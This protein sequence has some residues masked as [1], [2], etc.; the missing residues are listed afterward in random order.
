MT[1]FDE[2]KNELTLPEGLGWD[3]VIEMDKQTHPEKT[4]LELPKGLEWNDVPDL[5]SDYEYIKTLPESKTGI[6]GD[7]GSG[8]AKGVLGFNEMAWRGLRSLDPPGG[9][10]VVRDLATRGLKDVKSTEEDYPRIFKPS[11][12]T[13]QSGFRKGVYETFASGVPSIGTALAVSATGGGSLAVGLIT[14]AFFGTSQYDQVLEEGK[15]AGRSYK[16]TVPYAIASGLVEGA[17]EGLANAIGARIFGLDGPAAATFK[18]T[19]KNALFKGISGFLKSNLKQLPVELGTEYG[20]QVGEE[21][22]QNLQGLSDKNPF[23]SGLD[24]IPATIG[25]T[26]LFGAG[27]SMLTRGRRK[28]TLSM[29]SDGTA[30]PVKRS[31]AAAVIGEALAQKDQKLASEWMQIS[32]R[33]I[34]DAKPMPIDAKIGTLVADAGTTMDPDAERVKVLDGVRNDL[35]AGTIT[36]AHI[37]LIKDQFPELK[38]D[39][40]KILSDYAVASVA[41][42]LEKD[43]TV[44]KVPKSKEIEKEIE[45]AKRIGTGIVETGNKE[46][47]KREEEKRLYLRDIEEN[48]LAATKGTPEEPLKSTGVVEKPGPIPTKPSGEVVAPGGVK[49][50]GKGEASAVDGTLQSVI[51]S[52]MD[53]H[54]MARHIFTARVRQQAKLNDEQTQDLFLRSEYVDDAMPRIDAAYKSGATKEDILTEADKFAVTVKQWMGKDVGKLGPA[55]TKAKPTIEMLPVLE[56]TEAALAFGE[57]ATVEQ[58]KLLNQRREAF[59]QRSKELKDAGDYNGAMVEATNAQFD[60]EA[61]EV[62]AAK[63]A[64]T[65][66]A[67]ETTPPLPT[68]PQM[69]AEARRWKGAAFKADQLYPVE[70]TKGRLKHSNMTTKG[71]LDAY[72]MMKFGVDET[73]ARNVSNELTRQNLKPA[74]EAKIEDFAGE[75]WAKVK[76]QPEVEKPAVEK[77]PIITEFRQL[78]SDLKKEKGEQAYF[79]ERLKIPREREAQE[80]LETYRKQQPKGPIILYNKGD[81]GVMITPSSKRPGKWQIT[82]FNERGFIG[83][84]LANTEKDAIGEAYIEGNRIPDPKRAER[85]FASAQFREGLKETEKVQADWAENAKKEI[86]IIPYTKDLDIRNI[87]ALPRGTG[88]RYIEVVKG[89]DGALVAKQWRRKPIKKGV[90]VDMTPAREGEKALKEIRTQKSNQPFRSKEVA[91]KA[92]NRLKKSEFDYTLV[93]EGKGYIWRERAEKPTPGQKLLLEN[94]KTAARKMLLMRNAKDIRTAISHSSRLLMNDPSFKGEFKDATKGP[95]SWPLS[96][97]NNKT[98][99]SAD[100]M[101]TVMIEAGWLPEGATDADLLEA[102]DQNITQKVSGENLEKYLDKLQEQEYLRQEELELEAG[103]S[104]DDVAKAKRD[105]IRTADEREIETAEKEIERLER[106]GREGKYDQAAIDELD[107]WFQEQ[108][109]LFNIPEEPVLKPEELTKKERL[110]RAQDEARKKGLIKKGKKPVFQSDKGIKPANV[111]KQRGLFEN[112]QGQIDI[113]FEPSKVPAPPGGRPAEIRQEV[114][115]SDT[116][117]TI[118]AASW[119]VRDMDEAASLFSKFT[120]SPQEKLFFLTTDKDGKVLEL[121][122]Y[123]TGHKSGAEVRVSESLGHVFNIP[124]AHTVYYVHNHPSGDPTSSPEDQL[125]QANLKKTAALADIKIEGFIIGRDTY[126]PIDTGIH[127]PIK[128]IG[129][130]VE[131]PLKERAILIR[132]P[133]YNE[134]QQVEGAN[135]AIRVIKDVYQNREGFLLLDRKNRDIGFLPFVPGRRMKDT[136]KDLVAITEK[137]NASYV[138]FNSHQEINPG[139]PRAKYLEDVAYELG[140]DPGVLDIL[141]PR[142]S[143]TTLGLYEQNKRFA[144]Q[145]VHRTGPRGMT[146]Q[147]IGSDQPLYQLREAY[148][149]TQIPEGTKLGVNVKSLENIVKHIQKQWNNAPEFV[150]VKSQT[151]LPTEL[152]KADKIISGIYHKGKVYLVADNMPSLNFTRKTIAHETLGHYGFSVLRQIPDIGLQLDTFMER[153]YKTEQKAIETIAERYGYDVK[154]AQGRLLASEEWLA[155]Q[156]ETDPKNTWVKQTI[157]LIRQWLAKTFPNL[158]V[159]SSEVAVW[160]T[161]MQRVVVEGNAEAIGVNEF[162]Q[163]VKMSMKA[164]IKSITDNPN[165]VKWFGDTEHHLLADEEG[166]PIVVYRGMAKSDYEKGII[167]SRKGKRG[168]AVAGYFTNLPEGAQHYANRALGEEGVIES[169]YVKAENVFEESELTSLEKPE[170]DFIEKETGQSI[171]DL[172][173]DVLTENKKFINALAKMGYDAISTQGNYPYT[174]ISPFE[175]SQIK[176]IYNTG[177]WSQ[178]NPDIRYQTRTYAQPRWQMAPTQ[179]PEEYVKGLMK[180][181]VA[182][183][184]ESNQPRLDNPIIETQRDRAGATLGRFFND[185]M[186]WI[187]DKNRPIATVQK[188]LSK[189]TD[190][191]DVFLKETQRPKITAAKVRKAWDDDIKPLIEK[192]AANKINVRDLELYKHA[193]HAHEA[194][195]A[196]RKANSKMQVEKIIN[197]LDANKQK[198]KVRDIRVRIKG[199]EKPNE[200]Y[201]TLNAITKQYGKEESLQNTIAKWKVFSDKPSGMTD[202]D[203]DKILK[204]YEGD[205]K[206]QEVGRMLDVINDKKLQLLFDSGLLAVEEYEAILSKYEHYV[207]LYREG[208]S[209]GVYGVSRGLLP[210][211][212]P[213]KV[214]GGSTRN[215]VDILAHSVSNYEKA[216]NASEKARSQRALLGLIKANPESDVINVSPV[217]KSPRHDQH[218]NLRMYPDLFNVNDNEMRLMVNGEQHLVVV[219]RDNKDAMLMLRTLK[220]EDGATGPIINTLAKLNRFLAKVNTTW[221]PE[222]ILSNFVRDIQTAGIN[223]QD[224]GV[225]A[226]GLFRGA[227]NAWGAIF[228]TE[229][230]KPKGTELEKYYERFKMAGG[231]IGWSDVHGSIENLTRKITAEIEMQS[232]RRPVRKTVHGWLRLIEDTNT[233]IENGIRLHV[234]KLAVDQG[235]T[236]ER[237]AQVASDLTVDFTKKGAAGPVINS[238]YLFANAG[239]Q[240]SYRIARAASKSRK[241]Q[242]T[243]AGIVG[244]GFIIGILNALAGGEDDDGEDYFNKIDDFIRERNMIIMLPGTKGKYVKIPLPWGYNLFWNIGSETARAFTKR[245]FSALSSAGRLASVFANAFNPL[246]A[247]TLMQTLSPTVTDPFVQVAENK[248]WFGGE[249]MPERN[250]F[251]KIPKPD[252]QR[253]W[254]STGVM[255]KWI[256]SR[257]NSLTGGDKIKGGAIDVSPETLELMVDTIG[258]SALRFVK[259]TIGVPVKAFQEEQVAISRIPF[260]RRVAGEKSEWADSKIFYENMED[261]FVAKERLKAYRGTIEFRRVFDTTKFERSLMPLADFTEKRLRKL[262]N[263]LKSAKVRNNKDAIDKYSKMINNTYVRFN[264]KFNQVKE[265]MGD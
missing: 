96:L 177:T 193:L 148:R 206:I 18:D 194:N 182:A 24:V 68:M 170:K 37:E 204:Q 227:M 109:S 246:A 74:M 213:I 51:D 30:P 217:K 201:D 190:D 3:D 263:Y 44:D 139:T 111:G 229:R 20:Q 19:I 257:L 247:G 205:K 211:G 225:K 77:K 8:I 118:R 176:S 64:S 189:V 156:A 234:F 178:A 6:L 254:K 244:A 4:S 43:I 61:L 120:V 123:S 145:A 198:E 46:E 230:G 23:K 196:L 41:A 81:Q 164:A 237:A 241:V 31:Q 255:S 202:V 38:T 219:Q 9:I 80:V 233:S 168:S 14:S 239:I 183:Q 135:D 243:L 107:L 179:T 34:G 73:I 63:P 69:I 238:L 47:I 151:E 262:R 116:G 99:I 101:V 15:Q 90:L 65:E 113:K 192:M 131:I 92:L 112:E 167:D 22:I 210:S 122:H 88:A 214:R 70:D 218:G 146:F 242:K 59:I 132:R 209:D 82:S 184:P 264:K 231:K 32:S 191:V 62:Q 35:E 251:A 158:K 199:V 42:K 163:D 79:D 173:N 60:R 258:G 128:E 143:H 142:G 26:L 102:I 220:V 39:L 89:V 50:T 25:M 2:K 94:E 95:G 200:W 83:D 10:D 121:H 130:K 17:G 187:V 252:S 98:G 166:N 232:G 207:P 1:F 221:S 75:P 147:E 215:V 152:N 180:D 55:P 28:T 114:H 172:D 56:N 245:D 27:S 216:I 124:D 250:K 265:R 140:G 223:I 154:D 21:F 85:Q 253:Y 153:L 115:M 181:Y 150:I 29:L 12:Q 248:S 117:G 93:K 72:L 249:L 236:D 197:I 261:I 66:G 129:G 171:E 137:T 16:E 54:L 256:T 144:G 155:R 126:A 188:H 174:E 175:P 67:K 103:E 186:Y 157:A 105:G 141:D 57:T 110:A 127:K 58:R 136:T 5:A 228:A 33:Y 84:T 13:M 195:D 106:E 260:V 86:E 76:P 100:E 119:T 203:A 97:F 160:L 7:I 235:M 208:F 108:Q 36:S 149:Q 162:A 125:L 159:S 161:Q 11:R 224:T 133:N 45:N 185:T 169:F 53:S 222:F 48:R 78:L 259:D 226:K 91:R 87:D 52:D 138:V 212:R 134:A 165:F 40:N 49:A 71:D 240:G 104:K